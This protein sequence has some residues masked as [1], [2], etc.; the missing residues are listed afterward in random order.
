MV[1]VVVVVLCCAFEENEEFFS[2]FQRYLLNPN[3]LIKKKFWSFSSKESTRVHKT[4]F[5]RHF[6]SA[7]GVRKEKQLKSRSLFLS[8]QRYKR[9]VN[10][11]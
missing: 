6:F 7:L 5:L 10:D 3:L 4:F 2:V 8:F 11:A 1:V 9:P